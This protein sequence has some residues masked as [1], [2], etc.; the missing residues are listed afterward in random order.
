MAIHGR[1]HDELHREMGTNGDVRGETAMAWHQCALKIHGRESN[2]VCLIQEHPKISSKAI[3]GNGCGVST[4]ETILLET[5]IKR[6]G[7]NLR[8]ELKSRG[9]KRGD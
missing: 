8:K 6:M 7:L 9:K 4:M 1:G 5:L 3:Y 2:K